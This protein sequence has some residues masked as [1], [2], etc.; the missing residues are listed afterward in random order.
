MLAWWAIDHSA[1]VLLVYCFGAREHKYLDE[2]RALLVPFRISIV[3]CDDN[4][5]YKTPL[6]KVL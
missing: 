3:Y 5:A 1:G 2:L 4:C 6:Q